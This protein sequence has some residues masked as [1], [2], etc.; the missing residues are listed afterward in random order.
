MIVPDLPTSVS[1]VKNNNN[2]K[3]I[4]IVRINLVPKPGYLP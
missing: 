1:G 4:G 3:K 2:K